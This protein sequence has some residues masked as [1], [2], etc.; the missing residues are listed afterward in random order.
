MAALNAFNK[1]AI[2]FELRVR[3]RQPAH[4]CLLLRAQSTEYS[5]PTEMH[6]ST[7]RRLCHRAPRKSSCSEDATLLS[8]WKCYAALRF[9]LLSICAL[10]DR[11][12]VRTSRESAYC[13]AV[14]FQD[15]RGTNR[16]EQRAA[17]A[18]SASTH[19]PSQGCGRGALDKTS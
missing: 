2:R 13:S 12:A 1:A 8:A 7:R 14:N 16:F 4:P 18:A 6:A 9:G 17:L 19:L 5:S 15:S 10:P 3:P 11:P